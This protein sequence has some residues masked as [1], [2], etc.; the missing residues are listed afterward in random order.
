MK[1][2]YDEYQEKLV[3]FAIISLV[4]GLY[5]AI[6]ICGGISLCGWMTEEVV[7]SLKIRALRNIL[8]QGAEYFDH[9]E[10]S[11]AKLLQRISTDTTT[12]K[13][14]LDIRLYHQVNNV[15]CCIVE[16]VIAFFFCWRKLGV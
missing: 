4:V 9:P 10:T 2:S 12:L 6:T 15:F 16:I 3:W 13:A 11:N 8:G 7:D 5:S 1:Y 14:A